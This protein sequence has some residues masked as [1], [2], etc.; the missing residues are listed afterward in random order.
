[1]PQH[2]PRI[3]VIMPVYNCEDYVT[4]AIGSVQAQTCEDWE[5]IC[6]DDASTD[7]S[8]EV[9]EDLARS[10]PRITLIRHETNRG[11]AAA[12]NTALKHARGDFVAVLDS[13]DMAPPERF[14]LSLKAFE[15]DPELVLVG[16]QH[17]IIGPEGD[18]RER[19]ERPTLPNAEFHERLEQYG[20]PLPHSSCMIRRD[21]IQAVGGYDERLPASQD[22]DM[23]LRVSSHGHCLRLDKY[24]L[25]YRQRPGQITES[26]CLAQT[27][28]SKFAFRR[29]RAA[30]EGREFDEEKELEKIRR[31]VEGRHGFS[32][33][34]S[35]RLRLLALRAVQSGD[36][37][38]FRRLIRQAYGYWPFSAHTLFWRI[39]SITP[40]SVQ[41]RCVN[42]WSRL[43]PARG[44][45]N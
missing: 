20:M 28:Y 7:S 10:D 38:R 3:S 44:G 32:K 45:S 14:E 18:I 9:V 42:L 40:A 43:K 35:L 25:H 33:G 30:R 29:A 34:A 11:P 21:V 24:L 1:M 37:D 17:A 31:R 39:V 23:V 27:L 5:L 19:V 22:Y 36:H 16:G 15:E 8:A 12:R 41:T 4:E 26:R 13:D 2:Q 6:V